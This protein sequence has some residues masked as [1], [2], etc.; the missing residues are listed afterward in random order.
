MKILITARE[1]MERGVWVDACDLL[2]LDEWAVSEGQMDVD[3]EI[4]LDEEQA[5]KLWLLPPT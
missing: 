3:H 4:T 1:L 2:G 5:R